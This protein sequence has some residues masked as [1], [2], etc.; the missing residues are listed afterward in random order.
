MKI[1]EKNSEI[2]KQHID[3]NEILTHRYLNR[4]KKKETKNN[5]TDVSIINI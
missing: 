4:K 5:K 3:N 2:F 1:S